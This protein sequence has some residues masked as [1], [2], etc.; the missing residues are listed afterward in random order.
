MHA[1]EQYSDGALAQMAID[2]DERAFAVLLR[3]H[4]SYLRAYAIRLTGSRADA[5]D[6]VQQAFITA[7]RSLDSLNEPERFKAWMR[8]IVSNRAIDLI[9]SRRIDDGPVEEYVPAPDSVNPERQ[10]IAH[11]GLKR[12]SDALA[13]LPAAQREVWTM[14]ELGG[15]SYEEIAAELGVS[16]A[17][18]RGR[19]AR[20]RTGLVQELEVWR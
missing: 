3:R 19:L 1:Q 11:E 5:D 7:W 15:L 4:T 16:S 20:A 12:L 14:R 2:G 8:R 6:V 13:K 18:V 17:V 10:A 9:R